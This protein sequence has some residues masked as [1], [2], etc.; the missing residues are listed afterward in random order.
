MRSSSCNQM[1]SGCVLSSGCSDPV[2]AEALGLPDYHMIVT[3]PMDLN[4][5]KAT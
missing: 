1:R 2:D 3:D 4:T 5:I